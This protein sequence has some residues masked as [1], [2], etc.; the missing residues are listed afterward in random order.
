MLSSFKLRP[1]EVTVN[2]TKAGDWLLLERDGV[3]YA[4]KAA[5]EEWRV[6]LRPDAPSVDMKGRQH[7]ALSEVAGFDAKL[8][9]AT[10]SLTLTFAA[11]SFEST[12]QQ[13]AQA[14]KLKSD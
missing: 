3:L 7:F 4:P 10:Q 11:R 9:P 12:L 5:L 13:E 1:L 2:G 8:D 14:I 6:L